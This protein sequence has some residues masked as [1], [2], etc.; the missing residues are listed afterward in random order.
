MLLNAKVILVIGWVILFIGTSGC[1]KNE[2]DGSLSEGRDILSARTFGEGLK[3]FD[4]KIRSGV[5]P[6]S[7]EVLHI[8]KAYISENDQPLTD[9]ELG[10]TAENDEFVY[11]LGALDRRR[12]KEF[13]EPRIIGP[14][15]AE[16]H[17]DFAKAEVLFSERTKIYPPAKADVVIY[18]TFLR[19]ALDFR[20]IGST[21]DAAALVALSKSRNPVY[22]YLALEVSGYIIDG[23][24]SEA[25]PTPRQIEVQR[26]LLP[27]FESYLDDKD[28]LVVEE[29]IRRIGRLD[30]LEAKDVLE[31]LDKDYAGRDNHGIIEAIKTAIESNDRRLNER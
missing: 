26:V 7:S 25:G 23:Q 15:A 8:W 10:R 6:S 22:R 2:S 14:L 4:E 27:F 29:T 12:R 17:G 5:Y 20:F 19:D 28:P 31:K 13:Y 30:S 9:Q 21:E 11:S 16:A 24:D 18:H 3:R 1:G